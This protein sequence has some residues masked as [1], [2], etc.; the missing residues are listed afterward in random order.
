MEAEFLPVTTLATLLEAL[1]T[2]L[3]RSAIE[4][5]ERGL[6]QQPVIMEYV[7]NRF[8]RQIEREIITGELDLF[9]THA[10][11]EAQTKDYL[12]EAQIQLILQPLIDRLL[13]HFPSQAQLETHL[14]SLVTILRHQPAQMAGYAAGNLRSEE[15]R[16]GKEC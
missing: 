15:R 5:T 2:L 14:T 10:V 9:K 11:I 3:D 7:T 4:T 6:T 8:V 13:T 12:R 1:E 16:V